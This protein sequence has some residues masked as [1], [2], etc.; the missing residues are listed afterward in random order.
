[1]NS[2]ERMEIIIN[3]K[4]TVDHQHPKQGLNDL[5]KA[6]FDNI[7]YDVTQ[8]IRL[9]SRQKIENFF[10]EYCIKKNTLSAL[11]KPVYDT[12]NEKSISIYAMRAPS[13]PVDTKAT[14][15]NDAQQLI[16]VDAIQLAA[17]IGCTKVIAAPIWAGIVKS[18]LFTENKQYYLSFAETAKQSNTTILIENQCRNCNG[19]LI[20]G[21]FSD[22]SDSAKFIDELNKECGAEIFGFCMNTVNCNLCGID[23]NSF[24]T[25]LGKRIKAVIFSDCDGQNESHLLPF[26]SACRGNQTDWLSLIR[27]LREA[28]FEGGIIMD[29]SDTASAF[30]PILR[31]Q[32]L[33]LTKSVADYFKW[34]LEIELLLKRYNKRVLFG[35]GNMYRN[36]MKC[37]GEKYPPL[38][39]CD[40]N[41]KT[42]GTEFCGLEVK[43]PDALKDIPSDCAIFICNIYYREIEQQ[44]H[45]M[46]I[47]NPI[48]YF[49]DEYMPSFY[50]DR[51]EK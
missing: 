24:A 26:T 12:V 29:I 27:G 21:M 7:I 2:G 38:F 51:L 4:G 35:A 23:M 11:C 5:K 25:A 18:S 22:E 37:Y 1:M 41:S 34:Q 15:L 28:E 46:G 20:R 3:T 16:T 31:P 48:E 39:T 49:N 45:E 19:H 42:W 33:S 6:G 8:S 9:Q 10:A 40:N 44:L 47:N 50:F 32:L 36:Y 13:L 17:K 14:D 30:S 43:A